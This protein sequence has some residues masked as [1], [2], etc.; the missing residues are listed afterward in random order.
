LNQAEGNNMSVETRDTK[1][2]DA[3]LAYLGAKGELPA[4]EAQLRGFEY[5]EKGLLDS[6]GIVEM[7]TEFEGRFEIQFSPEDLQSAE[8]R[9]IGG[10]IDL[11]ERLRGQARNG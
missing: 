1:V 3:V 8:F 10:L 7:I 4:D 6:F 11:L 9:T 2:K 5:L